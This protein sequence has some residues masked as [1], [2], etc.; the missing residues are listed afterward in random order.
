[1]SNGTS[2]KM[3]IKPAK[4]ASQFV[5]P[6]LFAGVLTIVPVSIVLRSPF[7]TA[8]EQAKAFFQE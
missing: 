1:M 3:R 8:E 6:G 4:L 2:T 7:L 5:L